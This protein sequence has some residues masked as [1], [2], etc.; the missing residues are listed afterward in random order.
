M[1]MNYFLFL[2]IIFSTKY[3]LMLLACPFIAVYSMMKEKR[4]KAY[5]RENFETLISIKANVKC[6]ENN[7][8]L[9]LMAGYYRYFILNVGQIPSHFIRTLIYRKI[10]RVK[11]ANKCIIYHGVELRSPYLLQIGKGS[12]IGDNV[13]LDARNEIVIGENVQINSR[14]SLWTEQHDYNDPYFRCTDKHGKIII[15]DR[16]WIG[17]NVTILHSVTIGEG[18]VVGAGA[19]VTKDVPPFTLVAGVPAKVMG[20]RTKDLKYEFD[21]KPLP[22]Y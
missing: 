22:F 3:I 21:G 12:I 5:L 9:L 7:S 16:A 14:V 11:V 13:I 2:L 1:F 20:K 6:G 17:P 4:E 18:A 10:L 8:I 19:V 15:G